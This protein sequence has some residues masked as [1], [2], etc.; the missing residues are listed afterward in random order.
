MDTL[1]RGEI[2]PRQFFLDMNSVALYAL[3]NGTPFFAYRHFS[4]IAKYMNA[5]QEQD[6]YSLIFS[7]ISYASPQQNVAEIFM[8]ML[9]PARKLPVAIKLS[10]ML[11]PL[12]ISVLWGNYTAIIDSFPNLMTK[13]VRSVLPLITALVVVFLTGDAWRILGTLVHLAIL[14]AGS[15]ISASQPA[16][17]HTQRLLGRSRRP[18]N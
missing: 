15:R 5:W 8:A 7:M 13:G 10:L 17:P 3:S 14:P 2:T 1:P 16:F 4:F 9:L 18:E 12:T 6:D 11:I